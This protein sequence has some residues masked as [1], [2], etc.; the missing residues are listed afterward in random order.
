MKSGQTKKVRERLNISAKQEATE[1]NFTLISTISSAL[2]VFTI[3]RYIN[4]IWH[5]IIL[6]ATAVE[7][8]ACTNWRCKL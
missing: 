1:K 4:Y 5:K 6:A 3:M 8:T 7:K 2:E